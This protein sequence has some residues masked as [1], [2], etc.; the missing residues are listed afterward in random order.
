MRRRPYGP[1]AW[2]I[3]ELDDPAGWARSARTLDLPFGTELVPGEGSVVVRCTPGR[4]GALGHVLDTVEAAGSSSTAPPVTITARFDGDDL[5]AVADACD[6]SV[7]A[8]VA[9]FLR[10]RYRVAFCGFSPGFAYLAGLDPALHVPRRDSPRT[11]VPAG[12]VAVAA[13]YAAVYPSPSP[14][15]WHLLGRT[16]EPVWDADGD[17]PARL[18]PGTE[19]RFVEVTP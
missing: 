14:G 12:S 16:D 7:E 15:G 4:A 13:H 5:S 1:D 9:R 8:V 17:P 11:R 2:L 6:L 3:D 18:T 19:V 10:G